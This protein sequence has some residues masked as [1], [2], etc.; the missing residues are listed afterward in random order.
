MMQ[1]W[2]RV[3]AAA[4]AFACCGIP[5]RASPPVQAESG[6]R[7]ISR[8][9]L[10]SV[11]T[12][13]RRRTQAAIEEVLAQPEFADLHADP[14]A[15]WRKVIEWLLSALERVGSAIRHLPVWL[16]WTIVAWMILALAAILAHL[17]Y[18]LWRVLGGPFLSSGG[19]SSMRRHEGKL[20]GITDLDFETVYAEA[21]R[22]LTA[23]DWVTATRY[24]YVAAILGLDRQG[25]IAFRASKTYRDYLGELRGHAGLQDPFGR[26]TA[27]FESIVY[28][29]K[30]ATASTSRDMAD[31]VESLLHEPAR[32]TAN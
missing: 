6:V 15:L 20:L 10:D 24:Y 25:A 1:H 31:T 16:L 27:R 18:T 5:A 4:L 3:L 11:S 12:A 8:G 17:L 23:G 2:G 13:D 28:A 7:A 30:A 32:T 19:G 26:L 29:G 22:L 21:R 14:N 9:K